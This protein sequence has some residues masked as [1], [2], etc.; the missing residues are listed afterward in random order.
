MIAQARKVYPSQKMPRGV[1]M[2]QTGLEIKTAAGQP[3]LP[4]P[5]KIYG[6]CLLYRVGVL[7][8]R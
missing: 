2:R 3:R 5:Y 1:F 4:P 6:R 8:E 7:H